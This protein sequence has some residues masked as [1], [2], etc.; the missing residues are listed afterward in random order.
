MSHQQRLPI[1][2]TPISDLVTQAA[3]ARR[4]AIVF[5]HDPVA[6]RLEQFAEEMEAEIVRLSWLE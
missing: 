2:L 1:S 5:G 4:L 6:P 3:R